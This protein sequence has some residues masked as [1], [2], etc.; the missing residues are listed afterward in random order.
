[1]KLNRK[2]MKRNL[3]PLILALL[4][5]LI[6]LSAFSSDDQHYRKISR[7]DQ[8]LIIE[9]L[10]DHLAVN[11]SEPQVP[12][13]KDINPA[14]REMIERVA[15]L[16]I[17]AGYPDQTFRPEQK[18]TAV[19]VVNTMRRLTT[20][21]EKARPAD[22]TTIQLKRLLGYRF[23]AGNELLKNNTNFLPPELRSPD[24][25]VDRDDVA[26]L[27]AS[28]SGESSDSSITLT[29]RVLDAKTLR[30]VL[31]AFV[32]AA[33]KTAVTNADGDFS[34]TFAEET[35]SVMLLA[36][37]EN[38]RSLELKK[39]LRLSSRVIFRLKPAAAN[40]LKTRSH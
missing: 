38:Y 27:F 32:A 40:H 35:A 34:I 39:D 31:S 8:A 37:A 7:L 14:Q 4:G 16:G 36:A 22:K 25:L 23:A 20:F 9:R 6:F 13:F 24:A 26:R 10:F 2:K 29:G 15:G 19:E 11:I 1:M 17:M 21:L 33:G 30:P 12:H 5:C 3:P 18:M 28:S